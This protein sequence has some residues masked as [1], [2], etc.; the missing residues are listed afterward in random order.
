MK[1]TVFPA[2][3]CGLL[4]V[5]VVGLRGWFQDGDRDPARD[6]MA[7]TRSSSNGVALTSTS[8][9]LVT[10]LEALPPS[11]AGT[12]MDCAL[13]TDA[14]GHLKVTIGL[15]QCFDYFLSAVGEENIDALTQRIHAQLQSRLRQPALG[16]AERVLGGYLAYLRG[17]A[18]IEK[19]LLA[20]EPGQLDLE[21]ARRQMEQIRALRRLYL[22][23]DVIAVFF[24]DDDAY[25]SYALAKLELMQNKK[26]SVQA[27][28]QQLA[29]LEQQLPEGIQA[30]LRA[31]NQYLDLRVLTDEWKQRAG[32]A[33]ELRQIRTSLV[34]AE[35]TTRLETLD[36]E[37]AA[38]EGRMS[39]WYGQRDALM[40]NTGLSQADRERQLEDLR[41]SRFAN[42]AERLRV[43][44]L[45]RI[46]DQ[47]LAF[48][49]KN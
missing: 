10:G 1:K 29:A 22:A 8:A 25:D 5:A 32:S 21:R 6:E 44:T 17:V 18:D 36:Q 27:R 40:K 49:G 4:L 38:W 33:E 15:R 20:P 39:D 13:E 11:L 2:L 9:A 41:K 30:S 12:E 43:Q 48:S 34:G 7:T 46:R 31:V 24:A 37:N 47:G 16:E 26:L 19:R 3:V 14:R 28:A 23:P 35:A 42:E 45:E